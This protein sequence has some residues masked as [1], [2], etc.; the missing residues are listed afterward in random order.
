MTRQQWNDR[1]AVKGN[2]SNSQIITKLSSLKSYSASPV[3]SPSSGPPQ[4]DKKL[5]S[6]R[7]SCIELHMSVLLETL[8][9][10]FST[11][12]H[13]VEEIGTTRA[14]ISTQTFPVQNFCNL[15]TAGL[16]SVVHVLS[17]LR[18]QLRGLSVRQL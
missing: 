11:T 18:L 2:D 8:K 14:S 15:P 12:Q 9:G 3:P 1:A 17:A 7:V 16:R 10:Q 5:A 13:V 4:G 6:Q